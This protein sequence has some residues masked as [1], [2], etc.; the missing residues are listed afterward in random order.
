VAFTFKKQCDGTLNVTER[1]NK[2][3][4]LLGSFVTKVA[5]R[6]IRL[7]LMVKRNCGIYANGK[8]RK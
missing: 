3:S 8:R 7:T 2:S 5:L 6:V 4:W 1:V